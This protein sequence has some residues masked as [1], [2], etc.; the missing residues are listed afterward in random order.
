MDT[1]PAMKMMLNFEE[2]PKKK[3]KKQREQ[4]NDIMILYFS[5][6]KRE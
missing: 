6:W 2:K 3:Q 4:N 5:V 1:I